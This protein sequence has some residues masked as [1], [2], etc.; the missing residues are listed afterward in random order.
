[1]RPLVLMTPKSLLRLP[2]ATSTLDDLTAGRFRHV[3][4]DHERAALDRVT[5][6]LL[7]SGKVYYDLLASPRQAETPHVAIGRV[8]LLYPFPS[9]EIGEYVGRYSNL[10]EIIWVQEEPRNMGARKFVLPKL[11]DAV[12]AA[13][14]I[15]DVSRPER[16]S[17]AEGY[18]AAHLAEQARIVQ[19]AFA[20]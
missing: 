20:G 2:A 16:S 19:E 17:P 4:W 8:E 18:P 5:R 10:R 3:L 13:V 14:A 15:H 6:L 1:M 12:P 11:R 9:A 7:C